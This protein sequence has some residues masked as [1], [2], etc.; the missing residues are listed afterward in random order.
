[1]T[2]ETLDRFRNMQ[3]AMYVWINEGASNPEDVAFHRAG[4]G[5]ITYVAMFTALGWLAGV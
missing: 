3:S 5:L 1:M 2:P 4:W